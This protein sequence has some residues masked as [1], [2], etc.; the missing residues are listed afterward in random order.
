M[1]NFKVIESN[2]LYKSEKVQ[3]DR[4]KIFLPTGN[5]VEWD[6]MVYPDFYLAVT[7][8]DNN[9]LLTKEWRQGPHTYLTQFTKARANHKTEK[10]N[11]TELARELKEEMGVEGGD[12]EKAVCFSQGERLT[13]FCTVYFVTNFNLAKTK[14]DEN[15]I[16]ELIKLPI[17]GL[18]KEL[19]TNHVTM[20]E[21]LLIAKLLEEKLS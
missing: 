13:G 17:R 4:E 1:G 20:A 2:T 16:Q 18:Y 10:E 21:S 9:V 5:H 19:S 11:L 8:K 7:I 15:E 12:Y 6:V 14:R 3:V